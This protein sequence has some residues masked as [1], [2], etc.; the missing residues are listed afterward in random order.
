MWGKEERAK[1]LISLK[2]KTMYFSGSDICFSEPGRNAGDG[3]QT[4]SGFTPSF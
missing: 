4:Y 3:T 1:A 2:R